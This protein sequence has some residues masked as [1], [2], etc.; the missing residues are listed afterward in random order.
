VGLNGALVLSTR[1]QLVVKLVMHSKFLMA[2][3]YSSQG[4]PTGPEGSSPSIE[5]YHESTI[6]QDS[7]MGRNA[8][9]ACA[10]GYWLLV[11]PFLTIPDSKCPG[12]TAESTV[13]QPLN[14]W[15][16]TGLYEHIQLHTLFLPIEVYGRPV[17]RGC[18]RAPCGGGIKAGAT[19]KANN[20]R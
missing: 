19:C 2:D 15:T 18:A 6:H 7:N 16:V 14:N 17:E 3:S 4:C 20:A 5:E 13:G 9:S 12:A 10:L 1:R 11:C 8:L